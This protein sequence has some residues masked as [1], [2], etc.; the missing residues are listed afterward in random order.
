MTTKIKLVKDKKFEFLYIMNAPVYYAKVHNPHFKYQSTTDKEF[1]LTVFMDDKARELLED[2]VLINKTLY[3][4]G[5][6]KNKKRAI[7]FPTE[8][9]DLVKDMHGMSVTLNEYNKQGKK[10]RL[11]VVDAQGK[12][13]TK[14]IGNGSVVNLKL[15][16]YRNQDGALVVQLNTVVVVDH[17]PYN[18]GGSFSDDVL[19]ITI[20]ASDLEDTVKAD[21]TIIGGDVSDFDEI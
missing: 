6:D 14:D 18:K 13:F 17:V 5:V 11:F 2:K 8:S 7:K 9:Y 19:G 10:G 3:K 16:G 15:F 21:D 12:P 4:V 20:D 1:G